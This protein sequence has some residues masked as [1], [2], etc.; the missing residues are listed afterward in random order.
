MALPPHDPNKRKQTLERRNLDLV[1][2][3]A[4]FDGRPAFTYP[5]PR[6]GEERFVTVAK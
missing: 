2:M 6:N 1:E 5:S 4:L 3:V